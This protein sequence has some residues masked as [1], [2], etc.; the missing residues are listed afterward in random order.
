M[1]DKAHVAHVLQSH[2]AGEAAAIRIAPEHDAGGTL[3][4]KLVAWHVR[5]VPA[6][7]RDHAAIGFRGGVDDGKNVVALVVATQADGHRVGPRPSLCWL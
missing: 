3:A 2:D 4:V 7:G 5:F 1:A 6:V